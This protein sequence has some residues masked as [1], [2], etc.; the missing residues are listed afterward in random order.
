MGV[1]ADSGVAAASTNNQRGVITAVPK[2]LSLGLTRWTL[3]APPSS[4]PAKGRYEC[5]ECESDYGVGE[6]ACLEAS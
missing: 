2:E 3:N 1:P 6:I 4:V 5:V